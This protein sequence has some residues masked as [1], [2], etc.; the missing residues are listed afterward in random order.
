MTDL[1]KLLLEHAVRRQPSLN[2]G[3]TAITAER[4]E[5]KTAALLVTDELRHNGRILYL[6]TSEVRASPPFAKNAKDGAPS[7]VG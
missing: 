6:S 4:D 7:V 5:V 2:N 1:F 3:L